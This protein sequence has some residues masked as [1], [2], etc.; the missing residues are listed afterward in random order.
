MYNMFLFPLSKEISLDGG[1]K[2]VLFSPLLGEMIHF[3]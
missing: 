2:H 3:D 1:F